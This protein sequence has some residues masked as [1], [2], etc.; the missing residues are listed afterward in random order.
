MTDYITI[1]VDAMGGDHAPRAVIHGAHLALKER[2][3]TRFIFH[4]LKE[5]I[6]PL[7]EEFPALKPVSSVRHCETV[8]AM[9]EK[10]NGSIPPNSNPTSTMG[11]DT[12][13]L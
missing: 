11:F 2:E 4:G 6:D 8:I 5:Q 1:S 12:S 10:R 3:N 7:L 13:M 9:D